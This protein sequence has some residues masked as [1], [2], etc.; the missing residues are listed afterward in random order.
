MLHNVACIYAQALDRIKNDAAAANAD[1]LADSY[2]KSAVDSVRQTLLL[3]PP[4]ARG[5]YLRE[6]ILPDSALDSV[7]HA[8]DLQ[9]IVREY[10]QPRP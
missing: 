5:S 1:A 9:S 3:I 7:R 2:R 6:K 8:A 4:E 10:D